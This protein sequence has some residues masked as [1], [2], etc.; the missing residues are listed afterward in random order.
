MEQDVDGC[1]RIIPAGN[2]GNVF[3]IFCVKHE[4]N[5]RQNAEVFVLTEKSLSVVGMKREALQASA[6]AFARQHRF[7]LCNFQLLCGSKRLICYVV[8]LPQSILQQ[9]AANGGVR[10]SSFV[11]V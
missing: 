3:P 8:A 2:C 4:R 11:Y 7:Y 1:E 10:M 5:M 6:Q 9:S